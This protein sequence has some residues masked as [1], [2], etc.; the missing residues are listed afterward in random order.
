M[1]VCVLRS[2]VGDLVAQNSLLARAV[3][4]LELETT[5]RLALERRRHAEVRDSTNIWQKIACMN[6]WWVC[7][8]L[9]TDLSDI[10]AGDCC[11]YARTF[12]MILKIKKLPLGLAPTILCLRC[13]RSNHQTNM[14][15]T[16]EICIASLSCQ[17]QFTIIFDVHFA[18]NGVVVTLDRFD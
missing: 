18:Y 1:Q 4:D 6:I 2:W 15:Y 10:F 8:F 5:T 9:G 7:V 11:G 12:E 16:L 3:E 14:A 13:R 17:S